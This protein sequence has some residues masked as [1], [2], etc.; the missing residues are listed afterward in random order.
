LRVRDGVALAVPTQKQPHDAPQGLDHFRCYAANGN[1]IAQPAALSDQFLTPFT[2]HFVLDPLLF[3]NPVQKT[4]GTIVT[5]I[6]HPDAHLTC[7]S[8]TRVTF[9]REVAIRNQFGD[10]RLVVGPPDILCVPTRKLSWQQI[11][12][13]NPGAGIQSLPIPE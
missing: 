3:C 4:H 6:Q 13:A 11:P 1:L 2:G 5:P 8:M 9:T 10:Q 7:Y 12:D